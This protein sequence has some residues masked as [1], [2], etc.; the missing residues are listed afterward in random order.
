MRQNIGGCTCEQ[1][2][3]CLHTQPLCIVERAFALR[4]IKFRAIL[5]Q[6][7]AA[8]IDAVACDFGMAC[9][10]R[11][12]GAVEHAQE[13][14]FHGQGKAGGRMQN[15]AKPHARLMVVAAHGNA[16][17]ALS[18]GGQEI[19]LVENFR[20]VMRQAKAFQS[21]QCEKRRIAI[22]AFQF[23]KPGL[24]IA[25]QQIDAQIRAQFF[26]HRL[27]A[28]RGRADKRTWRQRHQAFGAR[29]D[30]DI[31]HILAREEAGNIQP[32]RQNGWQVFG[33]MDRN[34]DFAGKL[35]EIDFLGEQTF[36]AGL[37]KGAV[38]NL[39]SHHFDDDDF[40]SLSVNA[41]RLCQKAPGLV[42]LSQGQRAPA[43]A[44]FQPGPCPHHA[45]DICIVFGADYRVSRRGAK[46][47]PF[48]SQGQNRPPMRVLGIETTCDE[49]A[50]AVVSLSPGG[51]G[52]ILSNEVMSQIAQHAA[53][54]GVVPE[55]AARAH[56]DVLDRLVGRALADAGLRLD[57][58]DGVAAAAGPGLIGGVIVGL[59]FGKALALAAGKP[60]IGV[61]HLEAHALTARLTDGVDF[62][63]LLLLVSGGHT[64]LLSVRGVGDYRRIG[65]TIDDAIGEAF[66]KVAKMLG[67]P[68]P[69]GP[70]VEKQA[71]NGDPQR[72]EF[73]R[74]M[75]RRPGA[76]FSFSGLKTAVR[77]E[78]ERIAPLRPHDVADV[79]ASFQAAVVDVVIDRI[80]GALRIFR[81]QDGDPRALVVAGG[82]AANGAIR[83]ALGRFAGESGLNLIMPSPALCTDN[84]AMIAWAGIERLRRGMIDGMDFPARPRWPLDPQAERVN[85]GKA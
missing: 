52:D 83:R 11:P 61:N 32:V 41:M 2:L 22:A 8:E 18:D 82:V 59:T 68:Y 13:S 69:G 3:P 58:I 53:Y 10:R 46:G 38:E 49:T 31:A 7:E 81:Q 60:F 74:P 56:L 35:G 5:A 84:G 40:D 16:D 79:C 55:I 50:A 57:Q 14:S 24:D 36:A 6:D 39:V 85:N 30:E 62:P 67:L 1:F 4:F 70:Q 47:R 73:P 51:H 21:S 15:G 78:V 48:S 17:G 28:Q 34:I 25:A 20:H 54:G 76:D 44:N 29:R 19:V 65:T 63:Y 64:Q 27:A 72:F 9:N 26:H 66:D 23:G 42:S 77:L 71:L 33:R 75:L 43:R 45:L 12:A 37:G 80:R